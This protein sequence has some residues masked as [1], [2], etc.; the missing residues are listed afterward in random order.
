MSGF[1]R[2][3]ARGSVYVRRAG[4]TSRWA[5][6][7]KRRAAWIEHAEWSGNARRISKIIAAAR[8]S[9]RL[10]MAWGNTRMGSCGARGLV[11]AARLQEDAAPKQL[12]RGT[13]IAW[14]MRSVAGRHGHMRGKRLQTHADT[15]RHWQTLPVIQG[16]RSR[17]GHVR[18]TRADTGRGK[19]DA[20]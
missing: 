12:S 16:R 18:L 3:V 19:A 11:K 5:R 1:G 8:A 13:F 6:G 7:Q 15:R 14:W 9:Y 17:H 10:Q 20:R 4:V 2:G